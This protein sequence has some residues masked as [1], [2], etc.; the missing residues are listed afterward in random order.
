MAATPTPRVPCPPTTAART[1]PPP[2]GT[3]PTARSPA[4]RPGPRLLLDQITSPFFTDR[5]SPRPR[6]PP[7]RP[8]PRHRRRGHRRRD[9]H[10]ARLQAAD[11]VRA[12]QTSQIPALEE[13]PPDPAN[14]AAPAMRARIRA[15]FAELH[16]ERDQVETQLQ[17]PAATPAAADPALL[18]ELPVLSDILPGLPRPQ[19]PPV[20]RIR[21]ENPVEQ[22]RPA[23][24]PSTPRSPRPPS[25][26][27]PTSP[28]PDKTATTT[29]AT[30]E[31]STDD[32]APM[33]DHPIEGSLINP[34]TVGE[35]SVLSGD[36]G[37]VPVLTT[38]SVG[39]RPPRWR[40]I[41][42]FPLQRIQR[43]RCRRG[44]GGVDRYRWL[45]HKGRI[46]RPRFVVPGG[47][48]SKDKSSLK[49]T[50]KAA[51]ATAGGMDI[52]RTSAK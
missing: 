17:G 4:H 9:A 15:R 40:G 7:C 49:S 50:S 6:R 32:T 16:L 31:P 38:D 24:P 20:R 34:T 1:T 23:R 18:D 41:V 10:A 11:Q 36:R 26:P 35:L 13:T 22:A 51:H 45:A 21:P 28:T 19:S 8:A 44:P 47:S 39:I 46:P 14:P 2:H 33:W 25:R 30:P 29:P 5:C 42:R 48:S 37:H 12:A 27:S 43:M 52:P 3:P